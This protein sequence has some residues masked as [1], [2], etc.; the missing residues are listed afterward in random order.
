MRDDLEE[1][2]AKEDARDA[3]EAKTR[4]EASSCVD[5][6]SSSETPLSLRNSGSVS[7]S[8]VQTCVT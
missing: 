5:C 8:S 3:D 6:Q 7:R 4:A 2:K 1:L